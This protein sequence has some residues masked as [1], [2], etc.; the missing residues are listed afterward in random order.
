MNVKMLHLRSPG[1]WD[2][3]ACIVGDHSA[4]ESLQRAINTALATGA[5]GAEFY[6]SDGEGFVLAVAMED[7]MCNVQT[8]YECESSPQ[9]SLREI[10]PMWAVKNFAPALRKAHALRH[11]TSPSEIPAHADNTPS[12]DEPPEAMQLSASSTENLANR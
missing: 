2:G 11:D 6:S 5:G 10:T 8:A 3:V 7:S 4:L 12:S 1:R 9:R